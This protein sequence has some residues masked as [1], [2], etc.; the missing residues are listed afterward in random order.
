M[1]TRAEHLQWCKDRALEYVNQGELNDAVVSM[2]SD[3]T[4]HPETSGHAGI[5]LGMLLQLSG[6]LNDP[7]K[8]RD[9]IEGFR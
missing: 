7:E 9:Y 4:K 8:V 6:H 5:K 2:M 3:L 1:K